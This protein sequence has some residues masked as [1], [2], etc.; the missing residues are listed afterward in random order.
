MYTLNHRRTSETDRI[1]QPKFCGTTAT[2]TTVDLYMSFARTAM[3]IR[4][5]GCSEVALGN[6]E[7]ITY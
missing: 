5:S 4:E 7:T 6:T 3:L 1:L 2:F